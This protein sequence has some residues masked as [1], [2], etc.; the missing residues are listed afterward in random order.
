[1]TKHD[2]RAAWRTITPAF[3]ANHENH[4]RTVQEGNDISTFRPPDSA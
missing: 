4:E 2:S 3:S 1:M